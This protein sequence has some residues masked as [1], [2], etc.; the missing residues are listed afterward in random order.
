[1]YLVV[2]NV[3]LLSLF[4]FSRKIVIF[5]TFSIFVCHL[6]YDALH[7]GFVALEVL[8]VASPVLLVLLKLVG[9]TFVTCNE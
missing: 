1:M 3:D 4:L 2:F 5:V 6:V 9:V 8:V 7:V